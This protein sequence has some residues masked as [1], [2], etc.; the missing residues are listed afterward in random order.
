M[1]NPKIITFKD[2][3]NTTTHLTW[4][5]DKY[6]ETTKTG[7]LTSEYYYLCTGK[8]QS[9]N[10]TSEQNEGKRQKCTHTTDTQCFTQ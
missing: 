2:M 4:R 8:E 10:T 3:N 1:Y 6:T 9:I 5:Q 7:I